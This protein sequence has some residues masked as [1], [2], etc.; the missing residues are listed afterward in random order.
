MV[1]S[2][3]LQRHFDAQRD[4]GTIEAKLE[5][6]NTDLDPRFI[7]SFRKFRSQVL[8]I[9]EENPE[10]IPHVGS[11]VVSLERKMKERKRIHDMK[12]AAVI[13]D[14]AEAA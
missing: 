11:E 1:V 14:T 3:G 2:D 6:L 10:A 13:I 7:E 8:N 5:A 12:K 9:V 4:D